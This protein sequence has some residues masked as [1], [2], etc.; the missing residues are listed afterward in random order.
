[1]E[2]ARRGSAVH[3]G[4]LSAVPAMPCRAGSSPG[5][6]AQGPASPARRL[7]EQQDACFGRAGRAGSE[8]VEPSCF[9][10]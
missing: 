6:Q 9:W 2:G 10:R 8:S 3:S 4:H 7:R 5:V 1:M